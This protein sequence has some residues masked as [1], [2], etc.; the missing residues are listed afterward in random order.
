[1]GIYFGF[2]KKNNNS[3]TKTLNI[4]SPTGTRTFHFD[5]ISL[6]ICRLAPLSGFRRLLPCRGWWHLIFGLHHVPSTARCFWHTVMSFPSRSNNPTQAK[7]SFFFPKQ[8]VWEDGK[9]FIPPWK[10]CRKM[11]GTVQMWSERTWQLHLPGR[12]ETMCFTLL[13]LIAKVNKKNSIGS[14]LWIT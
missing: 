4:P 8:H 10:S 11:T 3:K 2:N 7:I 13:S 9:K 1:M 12:K 5:I 14:R 6:H